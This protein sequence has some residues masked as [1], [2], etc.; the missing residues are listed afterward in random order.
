[1]RPLSLNM[2]RLSLWL[3]INPKQYAIRAF[4]DALEDTPMALAEN[5]G[6]SPITELSEVKAR[7]I[8]ENNPFLGVDC[9]QTGNPGKSFPT[10]G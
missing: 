7:Q 8:K 5:S 2:S 4:A 10:R 9:L 3:H 6:L 1:M